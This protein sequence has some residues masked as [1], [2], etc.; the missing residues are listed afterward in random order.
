[1]KESSSSSSSSRTRH[2]SS[3]AQ[4]AEALAAP[5]FMSR[6]SAA[7]APHAIETQQP[8][9][10][11]P[12][13]KQCP[14]RF[15]RRTFFHLIVYPQGKIVYEEEQEA[16]GA[17][18]SRAAGVVPVYLHLASDADVAWMNASP[19]PWRAVLRLLQDNFV[20]ISDTALREPGRLVVVEPPSQET[21]HTPQNRENKGSQESGEEGLG[22]CFHLEYTREPRSHSY[23]VLSMDA[24]HVEED[25]DAPVTLQLRSLAQYHLAIWLHRSARVPH[26][27]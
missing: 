8:Q 27:Q 2:F 25:A 14:D 21:P 24:A 12:Q 13:K 26:V 3:S 15:K 20:T 10:L 11:P 7:A 9:K 19:V 17:S 4:Q 22:D 5:G 6:T 1:M 16:S 23:K 18:A